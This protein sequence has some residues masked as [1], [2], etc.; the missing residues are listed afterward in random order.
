MYSRVSQGEALQGQAQGGKLQ[1]EPKA[2]AET[3]VEVQA[4]AET[5]RSSDD[6]AKASSRRPKPKAQV[7]AESKSEV[8]LRRDVVPVAGKAQACTAAEVE[9]P[10]DWIKGGSQTKSESKNGGGRTLFR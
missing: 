8:R 3:E 9:T 1:W 7:E 4:K 5:L 2:K 6:G 10:G